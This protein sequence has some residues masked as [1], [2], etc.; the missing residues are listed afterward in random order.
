MCRLERKTARRGRSAVPRTFLRTRRWRR[1]R[2]SRLVIVMLGSFRALPRLA[3]DVLV[4]VADALALVRLGLADLADVGRHLADELLVGAPDDDAGRDGHLEGDPLE[5]LDVAFGYADHHVVDQRPGEPVQR[6]VLAL[7]V[8]TRDRELV[9]DARDGDV[10]RRVVL[11][12]ALRALDDH[13][14]ALDGHVD[15]GRDGDGLLADAGHGRY[16]TWQRTSPPTLRSRASRSVM[17]PWLVDRMAMPM[18]PSTR[19]TL[20]AFVYTRRPGLDTRRNP[21]IVRLRSGVYFIAIR[22]RGRGYEESSSTL[23]PEMYPSCSRIF[24]SAT[25]SFDDGITTSSW[26]ATFALRIRVSMSATGSVIV[27]RSPRRLREAGD[28]AVVG[29]V[30]QADAAEPEAPVHRPR[31]ATP[32]TPGIGPHLE[33]GLALLLLDQRLLRQWTTPRSGVR[34]RDGTGNRA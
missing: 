34:S 16:Q 21:E 7:V 30:A 9:A 15:A 31:A 19:G 10:V 12:R 5:R 3:A 1:P 28:L 8:G 18:P 6:A 17:R 14:A 2:A 27:M 4:D 20:S 24:A 23:E 26:N 29:H 33:L 22:R 32:A 13:V 11:E 25:F